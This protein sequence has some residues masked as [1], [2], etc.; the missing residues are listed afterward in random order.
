MSA[1]D[2]SAAD[3]SQIDAEIA[4]AKQSCS[5]L[6]AQIDPTR[7]SWSRASWSR[8]SWSSSFTK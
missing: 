8:A 3:I 2:L 1:P 4:A 6:L 7:A 5:Q